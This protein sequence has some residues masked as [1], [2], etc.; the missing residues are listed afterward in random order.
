[1][2][3]LHFILRTIET[4]DKILLYPVFITILSILL[5]VSS[6]FITSPFLPPKLPLLYSLPWGEQ[7]LIG[8]SQFLLLPALIV[9]MSVVNIAL[10]MQLHSS[11][12]T[13]KKML[14]LSLVGIDIIMVT[15]G[16]KILIIFV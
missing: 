2:K 5:L 9:G 4:T 12:S 13:L 1:M 8:K 15:T 11:H 6:F 16:I 10:A 14:L 7:Q 3:L